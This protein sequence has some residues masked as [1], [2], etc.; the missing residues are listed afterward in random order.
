[1]CISANWFH[2]LFS[3]SLSSLPP[4]LS[5]TVDQTQGPLHIKQ[6]LVPLVLYYYGFWNSNVVIVHI[7]RRAS[8]AFQLFLRCLFVLYILNFQDF[9][10]YLEEWGKVC[11]LK[12]SSGKTHLTFRIP[13]FQVV[14]K[15][16]CLKIMVFRSH[17]IICYLCWANGRCSCSF[18]KSG[19]NYRW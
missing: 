17:M 13:S 4:S 15:F 9:K 18:G 19:Q 14:M 7:Y 5:S 2:P 8:M 6:A 10:L 16:H 11:L 1:M 12:L 3:V